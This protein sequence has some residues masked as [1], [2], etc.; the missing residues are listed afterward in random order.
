MVYSTRPG[1]EI[2]D[3]W[4]DNTDDT[5][6]IVSGYTDNNLASLLEKAKEKWPE[7]TL[8][9]LDISSEKIHTSCIYYDL[10]DGSDYTDFIII[11][12]NKK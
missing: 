8:E 11:T 1:T 10:Y 6:Y 2:T 7:A 4:P 5:I 3:F 9:D 12:Y